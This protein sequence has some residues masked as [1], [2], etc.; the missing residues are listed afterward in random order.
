VKAADCMVP[1]DEF[2]AF[3]SLNNAL[4]ALSMIKSNKKFI[5]EEAVIF[6]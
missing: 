4:N 1:C 6:I 5:S 3:L 2:T